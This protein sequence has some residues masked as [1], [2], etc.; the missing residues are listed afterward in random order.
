MEEK[1]LKKVEYKTRDSWEGSQEGA[2]TPG[3]EGIR[4]RE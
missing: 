4:E 2:N 3:E 1:K